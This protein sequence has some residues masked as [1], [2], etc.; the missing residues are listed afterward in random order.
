MEY[1]K[2]SLD[3]ITQFVEAVLE[4]AKNSGN[5]KA[6]TAAEELLKK[7]KLLGSTGKA[8]ASDGEFSEQDN[9]ILQNHIAELGI[10]DDLNSLAELI[11]EHTELLNS[12][13]KTAKSGCLFSFLQIIAWFA[14]GT[15]EDG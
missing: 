10:Q 14:G 7:I 13:K 4:I 15:K 5:S 8:L 1:E 12:P 9:A 2:P 3:N 6:I 11:S